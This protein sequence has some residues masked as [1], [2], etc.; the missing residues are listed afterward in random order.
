MEPGDDYQPGEPR[1]TSRECARCHSLIVRYAQGQTVEGYTPGTPLCLCQRCQM[2]GNADRNASLVIGQRLIVR[3]QNPS[4]KS[5]MLLCDVQ[6]GWSNPQVLPS[7][8][9]P[10]AK[11]SAISRCPAWRRQRAWHRAE[12]ALGWMS[13]P[14][15]PTQL[16]L[17]HGVGATPH[18][19]RQ[20]TT[21]EWQKPLGFNRCGVSHACRSGLFRASAGTASQRVCSTHSL[22]VLATRVR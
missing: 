18:L 1:N 15:I 22:C 7:P 3:C 14:A 21:E 12:K 11:R 5:L 6:G 4:R 10:N 9:K 13:T 19:L 8:R 20:T 17:F 16:R 2:R